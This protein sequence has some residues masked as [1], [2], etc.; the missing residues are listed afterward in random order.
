VYALEPDNEARDACRQRG[1]AGVFSAV[2]LDDIPPE[3]PPFSVISAFDVIEH[4]EDDRAFLVGA[5]ERL[6]NGGTLVLSTPA[7]SF[8]WSKHDDA[9][10]HFRRYRKPELIRLLNDAGF[11]VRFATYW[12]M[13]LFPLAYLVHLAHT[14]GESS[15]KMPQLIDRLF[16]GLIRLESSFIPRFSLPFGVGLVVLAEKKTSGR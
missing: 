7:F 13:T 1:Y 6:I 10:L 9:A 12:N 5:H 11:S 4:I 3:T 15:R 2:R 8:L 14:S 16:F